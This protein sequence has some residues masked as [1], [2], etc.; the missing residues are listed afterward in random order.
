MAVVMIIRKY[1]IIVL[2]LLCHGWLFLQSC[3]DKGGLTRLPITSQKRGDSPYCDLH[4]PVPLPSHAR[5]PTIKSRKR[6]AITSGR[7]AL[8]L[9]PSRWDD[10]GNWHGLY[11]MAFKDSFNKWEPI[12]GYGWEKPGDRWK[13]IAIFVWD[14]LL[15][16]RRVTARDN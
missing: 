13:T 5:L 3:A 8:V 10:K 7:G 11:M 2:L 4:V 1:F 16:R 14:W 9:G 15:Y 6:I 12:G